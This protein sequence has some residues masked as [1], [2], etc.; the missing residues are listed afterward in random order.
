MIN[1][2]ELK[3]YNAIYK[4]S[5]GWK[6]TLEGATNEELEHILHLLR[7]HSMKVD[8]D[9]E[10]EQALKTLREFNPEFDEWAPSPRGLATRF[11][12]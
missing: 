8:G 12:L 11:G 6:A 10:R 2:N 5:E 7:F 3:I 1:E 4:K 9:K